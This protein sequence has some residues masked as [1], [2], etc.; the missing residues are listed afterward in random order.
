M[1]PFRVA[2]WMTLLAAVAAAQ[3]HAPN[4]L[5]IIADDVTYNDLPLYGG[6]NIQ[7]PNIDRLAAQGITFDR[8][9]LSMAMCNP[10]RTE[11]YTGLY[12][13]R[14]GSTWNHS[15]ARSGTRS[16]VHHLGKLGY[17]VGLSGKKHVLPEASFEFEDVPGVPNPR[18]KIAQPDFDT[19]PIQSFM[20]R[21]GDQPFFL[22][23]AFHEAHGPWTV[24]RPEAFDL[25]ELV[26]PE[27]LA[28]TPR[29]REHLASYLA[30]IVVLDWEIGR[31]L[32][33]LDASGQA[34]NT[35]VLFTS[36][37]G[38]QYPGNKWTNWNT[39]VHT[40]MTVRWPGR[41]KPGGRT[42]ALVQYADVLPTFI[43][44]A[45]G[46]PDGLDGTSFLPVLLGKSSVHRDYAYFMHNNIP[47]GPPYP[48][49][50]ITDGTWHYIRNLMPERI[51]IEKHVMGGF[52]PDQYWETWMAASG[53]SNE[54]PA[55]TKAIEL[56]NRFMHRPPEHLYHTPDDPYQMNN[57]V[58]D[59]SLRSVRERL[60]AALG[61]WMQSQG[62][63][64][65]AIDTEAQW[66]AAREGRHQTTV[67]PASEER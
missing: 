25:D 14:N 62:D 56:L 60:S 6:P 40:A 1:K 43:D 52:R 65:S 30:E 20:S 13:F 16:V 35:V 22:V 12:P 63:P 26:L 67:M 57:R 48:I 21:D 53:P 36:E 37:Q 44:A 38:S 33:A 11:L 5:L 51:Y 2:I 39:G 23:T 64:G 49:R 47:E 58:G 27:N 17:R 42:D 34:D 31:L 29:T 7:T 46:S 10:S 9:Y 8:A 15:A 55:N 45:G 61:R 50:A 28:D 18:G 19:N 59:Q 3:D 66:R 32:A 41:I 24:G 54:R 4:F